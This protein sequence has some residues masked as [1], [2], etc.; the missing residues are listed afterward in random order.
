MPLLLN[1]YRLERRLG[2]GGFGTVW[3]ARDERLEREV[4]VKVLPRERVIGGRFE[5]EARAAARLSHPGIVTL[6]EAAVDDEGAYLVSE[7]VRGQT[8]DRLLEAGRLSDRGIVEIGMAL[9]DALIHAH[10]HAVVHRD[11]KP[12]NVLIPERPATA[13]QVAKLTDFGVARVIGGDTLT[14]TGD[15]V[16]TAAYMAPEQAEGRE[17]GAAADLYSLSLVLYEALTG[18]NPLRALAGGQHPRRLAAHLPPVRR[19]RR[20]LPRDL[21][22]GIDLALRPRPRERGT[23][24]ELRGA[25]QAS[26][27]LVRDDLGVVGGP[28]RSRSGSSSASRARAQ[29]ENDDRDP[30]PGPA[31]SDVPAGSHSPAGQAE[32]TAP[33]IRAALPARAFAALSAAALAAW[34]S[35]EV[36]AHPA[37]PA[38]AAGLLAALAVA[39]LPRLGWVIVSAAGAG[40]LALGGH[41]GAALV[42]LV[43]AFVP[44]LLLLRQPTRW[45]LAGVALVLGAVGLA[46]AW[47]ALAAR[48][49]RAWQ[50]A[51]LA[52]TGWVWLLLAGPLV[53]TGLY[54]H[55]ASGTP[56]RAVWSSSLYE[57][58][59]HV[60]PR[61]VSTGRLLPALAWAL[62]AAALP[63]MAGGGTLAVRATRTGLWSVAVALSTVLLL[64][65][66]GVRPAASVGVVLLGMLTAWL[67]AL[68]PAARS[69]SEPS[70]GAGR[71]AG[72]A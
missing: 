67:V 35:T 40:S 37:L 31:W 69:A 43:G 23:L 6:Y 7:L 55:I 64:A 60:L 50:R 54:T 29:H 2:T 21:A 1:R 34:L 20:D 56:A 63:A 16:G 59:H 42:V 48:A 25:L 14:R 39:A 24:E 46:G 66:A 32:E 53:G 15:V 3:L 65:I 51:A 44:I 57:T 52:A 47:P 4:A 28:W 10:A 5:R 71:R 58:V 18:L 49:P 36:S 11:V 17:A 38:P 45:P 8:L 72:L 9:C 30:G 27:D 13:L 19:Y 62:G 22:R 41:G 33:S 70:V 68:G 61:A 12:S 26:L